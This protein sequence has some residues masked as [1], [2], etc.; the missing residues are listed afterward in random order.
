[1]LKLIPTLIHLLRKNSE[2]IIFNPE[3]FIE[4][5]TKALGIKLRM[6]KPVLQ[7]SQGEVELGYNVGTR[8]NGVDK[9]VWPEDLSTE[10]VR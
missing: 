7:F 2:S 9:P 8:G 4:R 1:M 6:P 3:F 10:I 5:E